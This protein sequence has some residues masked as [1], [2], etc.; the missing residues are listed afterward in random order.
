VERLKGTLVN[1]LDLRTI[2][3]VNAAL[4][5]DVRQPS[6]VS[7]VLEEMVLYKSLKEVLESWKNSVLKYVE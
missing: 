7:K 2:K 5:L 1:L 4:N 3:V 6:D